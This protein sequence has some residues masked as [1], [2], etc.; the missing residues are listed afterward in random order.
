M[1]L[2]WRE[3]PALALVTYEGAKVLGYRLVELKTGANPLDLPLGAELA[4]NFELAVAVMEQNRFHEARSPFRVVRKLSVALKP[5]ATTLKPGDELKVDVTVTDPQGKPVSAEVTLGLVQKNLLDLFGD[6]QTAIDDFFGGDVRVVSVRAATSATFR[7]EPATRGVSE[8]LLSEADR[9]AVRELERASRLRLEMEEELARISP[10]I[11]GLAVPGLA[12]RRGPDN[13]ALNDFDGDDQMDAEQA[14]EDPFSEELVD[15]P[16]PGVTPNSMGLSGFGGGGFGGGGVGG[17]IMLFSDG[18]YA[19]GGAMTYPQT[20]GQSQSGAQLGLRGPLNMPYGGP[21]AQGAQQRPANMNGDAWN[22]LVARRKKWASID[23]HGNSGAQSGSADS[24]H[25]YENSFSLGIDGLDLDASRFIRSDRRLKGSRLFESDGRLSIDPSSLRSGSGQ[26]FLSELAKADGTILALNGRGQFQAIN[27]L[28]P[29]AVQELAKDGL[30]I[31]LNQAASETGYWNPIVVTDKE[32]K[33]TVAF[34]I[35]DRSTAWT[36]R[37]KGVDQETLAGQAEADI[38]SKKDLFGEVKTPL[39]FVAGDK[40]TVLVEIHNSAVKKDD[41]IEVSL[42]TTLGEKSSVEKKTLVSKGPGMEELS[43]PVDVAAGDSVLFELTIAS[44]E[45]KDVSTAAVPVR[46]FGM[47]VFATASGRAAQ[48]TIAFVEFDKAL[49]AERPKLEIV[50]GPSVNRTLL[51]AVFGSNPLACEIALPSPRGG[52]ERA[53]SDILGG[54]ALL[55]SVRESAAP[56]S[57]EA[58]TLAG[59]VTGAVAQLVSAQ[60][61]GGEWTWSGRQKADKPDRYMSSRALWALAEARRAGF[62]VPQAT[63]DKGVQHLNTAFTKSAQTDREG[64]AIL[65]HGL[66]E[67]GAAD[68]AHANRLY[69]DRNALSASGLLHVALVLARLDRKEMAGEMLKLVDLPVGKARE[70]ASVD[71]KVV[72]WMQSPVELRALHLLALQ[73][74]DPANAKSSDVADWLMGAR[75]G[76]RWAPEKANGPAVAALARWFARTKFLPEKYALSVFVNDK[77]VEKI[78][79]DPSQDASRR[80]DVAERF[81]VA[82]KPQKVNF[83]IEGRGNFSYSAVLSGFVPA[84]KL[85]NTTN[86]WSVQRH[87]EPAQ[88][89]LDGEP[90]PR[91]F[92]VLSGGHTSFRNPLTQLPLGERGEVTLHVWRQNVRGT[93]DEQLDYLVVTEPVPAGTMV[94][95]ESIQG[96]F[97]RYEINPGSITF[98][99]GDRPYVGDFRYSL[100]GYLPGQY[101]AGPTLVRSFYRPERIAVGTKKPLAVLARGEKSADEYKLTPQELFEFGKRLIAKRDYSAADTHLT[102]L[103][104]DWRLDA[105][106]YQET[107]K[108]L[109]RTSLHLNRK[110]AIVEYFEIIKEKYPDVE[111]DYDSIL[112][113]AKAYQELGEYERSFLVYRATVEASFGRE[114]QITGFLDGQQRFVRSIETM[115]R[116]LREY[117]AESYVA[118]ATYALAQEVYGKAAEAAGN[119]TLREAKISRVDLIAAS[120][121][122]TEHFLST[123]PKDPAADQASFAMANSHLDLEQYE[124]A[125][126]RC[127]ESVERYADS[128]LLDSFWYII[129]FSQFALGKPDDALATCK[130]VAD[131]KT[132]DP[133]TG[134]ELAAANREQA[135]YIMGQVFHSLGKASQAISEYE[136]VKQKF[137]DASEAIDFF[138]R[139]EIR[140]PEVTT[141]KPGDAAK[142]AL[143]FRNVPAASVKVYRIDLLKFGLMQR[144]LDRITAINLAGIRPY[145]ELTLELGDGKDYRDRKQDV[146]LPLKEEGAYLVVCRAENLY[147]S[148]LV[149]VSPL[150]L[151]PQEDAQSGRVRV[152]VKDAVADKYVHG[153]H[154]KVIGTHNPQFISGETDLRGIFTA[155][156]ICGTTTVIAR[157]EQNRYAFHRGKTHLGPQPQPANAPASQAAQPGEGRPGEGKPGDGKPGSY[158]KDGLLENLRMQN[159]IFNNEQRMNYKRQ[160]EIDNGGVKAKAAF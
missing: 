155:D 126:A 14:I 56:D 121:H 85:K 37:A 113:V 119:E 71:S 143:D 116:L 100:V 96:P 7:Y 81:L 147:A 65:L 13:P 50:I 58:Q 91:G 102:Q 45:L 115:E 141:I 159:S 134:I 31:L 110:D 144:N 118:T 66:A 6:R 17:G 59:R 40:A 30:Q 35:P 87:Y 10:H 68:F 28:A 84:D 76:S 33:A 86:D 111:I 133:N 128:K 152:T 15:G 103:F 27:G 61:D 63:F 114:G 72:P 94:L 39:A 138:V 135:I 20:W 149:L 109:F 136:Q 16:G 44:G 74:I 90:V 29:A 43:F 132:K 124:Q 46:P 112:K 131:M 55:K 148:G 53:V 154:V 104:R 48:N 12:S 9:R 139:K 21:A 97:E 106:V 57:P 2:H 70:P 92:G 153:V 4:P 5:S 24:V 79:V 51:D 142:V 130:K 122:M 26:S 89:M 158:G 83:D 88:R 34:R 145:H 69:R 137:P 18:A 1:Q 101:Q 75:V 105:N 93:P 95:T 107:V 127:R 8:A 129:G 146:S 156:G 42:K 157:S 80:L 25:S 60:R 3:A 64:Q 67:A 41:K 120:I 77:L 52:L 123:W 99:V 32:G 19:N 49:P 22:K 98:Y 38:V 23:L 82:G 125:I 73:E 150:V 54:V 140:L 36:L 62:A 117:P 151:E 47:D 11:N 78:D 160:Q 108:L